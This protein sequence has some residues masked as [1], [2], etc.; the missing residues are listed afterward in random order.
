[1]NTNENVTGINRGGAHPNVPLKYLTASSIIG[2]KVHNEKNEH[3]GKIA[4]IW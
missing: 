1:M 3:L 2:D 4:D